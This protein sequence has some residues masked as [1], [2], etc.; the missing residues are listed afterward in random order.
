MMGSYH[1][2]HRRHGFVIISFSWAVAQHLGLPNLPPDE[3]R[4]AIDHGVLSDFGT[5][6]LALDPDGYRTVHRARP[7]G[8]PTSYRLQV[9]A[10][11]IGDYPAHGATTVKI[12]SLGVDEA[13]RPCVTFCL[14]HWA[15]PAQL[16]THDNVRAINERK[17]RSGRTA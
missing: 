14:P 1:E 5:M 4:L 12:V 11:R 8:L 10:A 16:M 15:R 9:S 6:R 3:Q 2:Q 17:A 7:D 13:R